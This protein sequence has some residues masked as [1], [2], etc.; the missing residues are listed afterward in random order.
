[1]CKDFIP[2]ID[3]SGNCSDSD[4]ADADADDDD[5]YDD[6]VVEIISDANDE[7]NPIQEL[8]IP[9]SQPSPPSQRARKNA[10]NA[11][12]RKCKH[13]KPSMIN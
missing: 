10:A 3:E 13:I 5:F 4:D 1:M 8:P 7:N 11:L 6:E 12:S 9:L 2:S